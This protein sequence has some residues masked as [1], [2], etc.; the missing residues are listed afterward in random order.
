[1]ILQN[2]K[3]QCFI[4]MIPETLLMRFIS[5]HTEILQWS[6]REAREKKESRQKHTNK[7]KKIEPNSF[8][9]EQ[10]GTQSI[11][12]LGFSTPYHTGN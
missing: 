11:Q 8:I 12:Y 2:L 10:I 9:K 3:K 7:G 5:R 6:F 4:L 1:M